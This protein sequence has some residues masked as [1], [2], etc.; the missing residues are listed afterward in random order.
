MEL[1]KWS[2]TGYFDFG[3]YII[4]SGSRADIIR[5]QYPSPNDQKK[6]AATYYVIC[7]PD[8]S[9]GKLAEDLY[10]AGEK[11]AIEIFKRQ[12]PKPRGNQCDCVDTLVQMVRHCWMTVEN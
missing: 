4:V 12:L 3:G 2:S 8:A 6:E 7:D 5:R 11:R 10:Q 1:E 9:W